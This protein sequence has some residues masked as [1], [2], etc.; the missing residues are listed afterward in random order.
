MKTIV[1][2]AVNIYAGGPLTIVRNFL[3][4][5]VVS[6]A[7][8]AGEL[9]I[10]LFC[11]SVDLYKDLSSKNFLLMAKPL[12][13]KNWLFRLFYEYIWFWLW[14]VNHEVDYWISLHDVTPNVRAKHRIVYCHNPSPFYNGASSWHYAPGF[15]MFR[16]F[17]KFLYRINLSKNEHIVV[18]QQW[19]R[20]A[21]V[22]RFRCDPL[23]VIVARPDVLLMHKPEAQPQKPTSSV[24]SIIFPA[25]P[26][27]FK[28]YEVLLDAMRKL[29]DIPV[30]LI[31]TLSGKENTY[32]K[33]MA[34]KAANLKNVDFVGFLSREELFKYYS[35]VDAMVFPSKLETWGLPLSEFRSFGKP[36]FAAN[37]SYAKETLSGYDQIC[38][39]DP[40][41]FQELSQLL[42]QFVVGREFKPM[43]FDTNY[44]PP[45]TQ[46]WDELVKTIGLT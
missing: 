3:G 23:K 28:N 10:I 39:F 16:R 26:R 33:K 22:S 44:E 35:D 4:T 19:I 42:R 29:A 30:R 15:E 40:D 36:I 37:L 34:E 8:M 17:Y 11:H 31:L 27:V 24:T 7:F 43:R 2:S 9:R 25:F 20:N 13:R 41:D 21:F 6:K 45:F 14:S 1:I 18:Q 38:Y 5:L 32:A 12:S 46:G